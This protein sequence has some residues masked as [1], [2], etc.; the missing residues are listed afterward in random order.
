ME[1]PKPRR[2][3]LVSGLSLPLET[4]A[5]MD[6]AEFDRIAADAGVPSEKLRQMLQKAADGA[7]R[8][9]EKEDADV[10]FNRKWAFVP[11]HLRQQVSKMQATID[12]LNDADKKETEAYALIDANGT[13]DAVYDKFLESQLILTKHRLSELAR[14]H[15]WQDEFGVLEEEKT[16]ESQRRENVPEYARAIR[17]SFVRVRNELIGSGNE[18]ASKREPDVYGPAEVYDVNIPLNFPRNPRPRRSND[19]LEPF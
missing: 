5:K 15:P 19:E 10:Q 1:Q 17:D 2:E 11:G 3:S 4:Y 13:R 7:K 6:P 18:Y 9:G 16:E 12:E 8:Q 14:K